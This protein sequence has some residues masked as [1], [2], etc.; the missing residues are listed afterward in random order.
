MVSS[1]FHTYLLCIVLF[2]YIHQRWKIADFGFTAQGSSR[3]LTPTETSRG[4]PVYR[5]PEL[6][7]ENGGYH[8]SSDIWAF[9]CIAYELLTGEK[10]FLLD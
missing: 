2:S 8:A 1:R 10:A 6:L 5:A 3:R 4:T 7:E 9:G